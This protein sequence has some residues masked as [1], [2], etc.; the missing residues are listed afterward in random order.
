MI[1]GRPLDYVMSRL[2]RWAVWCKWNQGPT[3]PKRVQS[4]LANVRTEVQSTAS[5][6]TCPVS[7]AEAHE[8]DQCVKALGAELKQAIMQSYLHGGTAEA[9]AARLGCCRKTYYNRLDAAYVRLLDL[10]TSV[11]AGLP[12]REHEIQRCAA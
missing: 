5:M 8:T 4:Q 7:E 9:K 10:F 2:G 1:G 3:G 12:I 6:E 11:A